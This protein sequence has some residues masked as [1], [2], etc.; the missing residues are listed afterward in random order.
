MWIVFSIEGGGRSSNSCV[1]HIQQNVRFSS[2]KR[3][4]TNPYMP[5]NLFSFPADE[6]PTDNQERFISFCQSLVSLVRPKVAHKHFSSLH[7][8]GRKFSSTSST[9][10][11]HSTKKELRR[12]LLLVTTFA[13]KKRLHLGI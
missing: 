2:L 11:L 8:S 9:P 10:I 7:C 5:L 4:K 12:E 6:C 1:V 3:A 13:G